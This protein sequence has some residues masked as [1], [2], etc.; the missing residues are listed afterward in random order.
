MCMYTLMKSEKTKP[1]N[2][3]I[4]LQAYQQKKVATYAVL[5]EAL[6]ACDSANRQSKT[7]HYVMNNSGKEYYEDTW[8][9]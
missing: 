8:I 7:R 6:T 5:G 1:G 9:D 4:G 2:G 3:V